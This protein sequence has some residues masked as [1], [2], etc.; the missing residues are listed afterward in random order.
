MCD[1]ISV[2]RQTLV[3][4]HLLFPCVEKWKPEVFL[5]HVD[6]ESDDGDD[7]DDAGENTADNSSCRVGSISIC[8]TGW[9][10]SCR[11]RRMGGVGAAQVGEVVVVIAVGGLEVR[12]EGRKSE[13]NGRNKS[14]TSLYRCTRGVQSLYDVDGSR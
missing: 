10:C 5:L 1:E 7:D 11:C 4:Y 3:L 2:C 6:D 9:W 12:E 8:S 14:D 13:Q